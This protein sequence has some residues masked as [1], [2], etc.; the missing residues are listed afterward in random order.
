MV[1]RERIYGLGIGMCPSDWRTRAE[2]TGLVEVSVVFNRR[3]WEVRANSG[4]I[5]GN[6]VGTPV[7]E[8]ATGGGVVVIESDGKA[9]V[10][11]GTSVQANSG[12]VFS[13]VQPKLFQ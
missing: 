13:P 7:P 4:F 1:C 9:F 8:T 12:R 5:G 11:S 10:P 3:R 6:I 2:E